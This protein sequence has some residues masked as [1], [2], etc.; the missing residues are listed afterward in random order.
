MA[1]RRPWGPEPK[2]VRHA[3]AGLRA[4]TA[5]EKR[6]VA[7]RMLVR[8]QGFDPADYPPGRRPSHHGS[9]RL[10]PHEEAELSLV[11]HDVLLELG[12]DAAAE[13]LSGRDR[14]RTGYDPEY[15]WIWARDALEILEAGPPSMYIERRLVFKRPICKVGDDYIIVKSVTHGTRPWF[16]FAVGKSAHNQRGD[17]IGWDREAGHTFHSCAKTLKEAREIA[18]RGF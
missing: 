9:L 5:G 3:L 18:R 7:Q 4:G 1:R 10:S 15:N 16:L 14:G 12:Y 2:H 8:L 11:A 6:E 13:V 17:W